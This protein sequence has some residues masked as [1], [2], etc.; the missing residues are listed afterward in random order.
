MWQG[1]AAIIGDP[2][3]LNQGALVA[4]DRWI[5]A[6]RTD[7][8][9]RSLPAKVI[10]DRPPDIH[11]ECFDGNGNRV[12]DGICGPSVVPVY[13]T[14]RTVAGE[15][16]TADQNSCRLRPLNRADYSVSFTDAQ[17]AKLQSALAT[18]VC[19]WSRP[20]VDQQPTIAWLTYQDAQGRAII[21]GKPFGPEPVSVPFSP[22]SAVA[23]CVNH[24]LVLH[25][26]TLRGR[27]LKRAVVYVN[28]RRTRVI[29]GPRLRAPVNL[30]GPPAGR[31]VVRIVGRT[32]RGHRIV[33][34]RR[35]RTCA[36]RRHSRV[37]RRAS[38]HTGH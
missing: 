5:A 8:S 37:R 30:R 21:G 11:D 25:L 36:A 22:R 6:I 28:G 24:G 9:S 29:A 15:P 27:R 18:G 12:S 26:R 4:I 32:I 2:T 7:G 23:G 31:F 3:E 16:I 19:D 14:P 17:W 38:P 10:A 20:G 13:G 1:P 34:R 33:S 35:Y